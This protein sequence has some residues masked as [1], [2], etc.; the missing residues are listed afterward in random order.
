[1]NFKDL[2]FVP[3]ERDIASLP[4]SC[5][6]ASIPA[7]IPDWTGVVLVWSADFFLSET[8]VAGKMLFPLDL[9]EIKKQKRAAIQKRLQPLR[10]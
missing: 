2:L 10:F 7:S 3:D 4:E 8:V 5:Y 1:M 9:K 6:T